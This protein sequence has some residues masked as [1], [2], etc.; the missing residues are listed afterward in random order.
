MVHASIIYSQN[1]QF[2]FKM[3]KAEA[4]TEDSIREIEKEQAPRT[5]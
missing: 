1:K 3:S 4:E 2:I 5:G